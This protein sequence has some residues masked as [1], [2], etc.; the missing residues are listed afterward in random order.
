MLDLKDLHVII[1]PP[2]TLSF[3]ISMADP[4]WKQHLY[5]I[6]PRESANLSILL[7]VT[8]LSLLVFLFYRIII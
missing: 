4:D 1:E 5:G 8:F 6:L 3:P 7:L 2:F